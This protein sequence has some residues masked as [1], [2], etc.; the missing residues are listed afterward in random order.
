MPK[1]WKNVVFFCLLV[2]YS[3]LFY[4]LWVIIFG[5]K[6]N[7]FQ[8]SKN[9][10]CNGCFLFHFKQ[11]KFLGLLKFLPSL[12]NFKLHIPLPFEFEF[13]IA[14]KMIATLKC[15][16]R[17]QIIWNSKNCNILISRSFLI[18]LSLSMLNSKW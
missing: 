4:W 16:E 14:L 6:G 10:V 1:V 5:K 17:A 15:E 13:T 11:N 8:F 2:S 12:M 9:F 7:L 18:I 3:W